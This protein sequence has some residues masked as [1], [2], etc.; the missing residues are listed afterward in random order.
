MEGGVRL[1]PKQCPAWGVG[2]RVNKDTLR[3]ARKKRRRRG[4]KP[5]LLIYEDLKK[6]SPKERVESRRGGPFLYSK[7]AKN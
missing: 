1:K 2:K 6:E 7:T 3:R 5:Q 4:K